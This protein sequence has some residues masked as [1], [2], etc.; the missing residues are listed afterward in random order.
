MKKIFLFFCIGICIF[1]TGCTAKTK[2]ANENNNTKNL[3]KKLKF[4]DY[5]SGY[6]FGNT[7]TAKIVMVEYSSYECIDCRNLQ[8]NI[9]S[10]LKTYI[11]NGSLLYIYKPVNHPK[12][13]NDEKINMYFAP[14]S[15]DD[16]ENIFNK[17]DSYS[18]KP[19]PILKS[20][21]NLKEVPVSHYSAMSKEISRELVLGK[22]TT[23]PTI[24]INGKKYEKVFTKKEFEKILNSLL[25]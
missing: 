9:G 25:N 1:F 13:K 18:R 19:Y 23:T 17:F 14:K 15:L 11:K 16:I 7:K 6:S 2:V 20:V 5:N 12:F 21:L 3:E 22:I 10:L 8:K 4:I 24:Y